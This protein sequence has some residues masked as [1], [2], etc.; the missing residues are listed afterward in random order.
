MRSPERR[1]RLA[2]L[3]T[4]AVALSAAAHAQL[5]FLENDPNVL[6][7]ESVNSRDT[8]CNIPSGK[9]AQ[10]LRQE[11]QAACT[12]G[13]TYRIDRDTITVSRGCRASFQLS[14]APPV[15][16]SSLT[17]ALRTEILPALAR[18]IRDEQN[19][20]STPSVTL[21]SDRERAL[22][23]STV[24][25][26]GTARVARN[27]AFWK[28]VEFE[29][30][31][32]TRARQFTSLGYRAVDADTGDT[33]A[34]RER[35][36][37]RLDAAMEAKLDN[38]FSNTRN[39]NPRFEL[40]TGEETFVSTNETRF[41]GTGRIMV[42]DGGTWQPVTF[43]SVYDWRNDAFKSLTYRPG[44][45]NGDNGTAG[46]RM[47]EDVEALLTRALADDVRRQ[48]GGVVQAVVNRRF[49]EARHGGDVTYTGKFGYSWNDGSWVTRG[50]E[51]TF[52]PS[53][54]KVRSVRIYRID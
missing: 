10:F 33:S 11:S 6:R 46:D 22:S 30:V 12:R 24:A 32:D 2:L 51:A 43:D 47:D 44:T 16:G 48:K 39:A 18:K 4:A 17:N 45:G 50:Y 7:C 34:R 20:S 40:L 21:Q 23:S 28:A 38:E 14:D 36:R 26:T 35:L 52:N 29:S 31:Y 49:R 19:L 13:T 3:A 1:A 53:G 15:S 37:S 5:P 41:T 54:M 42:L 25:Y 27:G 9:V 8:T